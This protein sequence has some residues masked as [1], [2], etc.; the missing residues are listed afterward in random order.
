MKAR[1]PGK[2]FSTIR[3]KPRIEK[4]NFQHAKIKPGLEKL[5]TG[6]VQHLQQPRWQ[7][8][9]LRAR[10]CAGESSFYFY[11]YVNFPFLEPFG[12][13]IKK[14]TL[15]NRGLNISYSLCHRLML[16]YNVRSLSLRH[17]E[18]RAASA[19]P[20]MTGSLCSRWPVNFFSWPK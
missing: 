18:S 4:N 8:P 11:F 5:I 7:V 12:G 6:P 19:A 3:K 10:E 15:H 13:L 9:Q 20:S 1:S 16:I 17:H 14:I 2:K